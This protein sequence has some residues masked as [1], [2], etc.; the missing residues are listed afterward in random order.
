MGRTDSQVARRRVRNPDRKANRVEVRDL[1]TS[2]APE[3]PRRTEDS[4]CAN[5]VLAAERT[6]VDLRVQ[7]DL[8]IISG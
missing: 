7:I 3:S 6:C 2:S 1:A 8:P 5:W 4:G